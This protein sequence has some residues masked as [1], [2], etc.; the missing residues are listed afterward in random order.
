MLLGYFLNDCEIFP[1]A[2]TITST[3]SV[4][5]FHMW[6]IYILRSLYFNSLRL[7]SWSH[8]S[9]YIAV[10]IN[11][12]VP[13]SSSRVV[14]SGLLLGIV[15]S[16]CNIWLPYF[17]DL[18]LLILL[19]D[20]TMV[21]LIIL[22]FFLYY[23]YYYYYYYIIVIVIIIIIIIIVVVVVVVIIIIIIIIA[24]NCPYNTCQILHVCFYTV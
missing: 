11:I 22:T 2:H 15:L 5:T 9:L 19:N 16:A 6:C 21:P 12:H 24:L 1:V 4:V 8:L 20:H 23:Y 14:K 7:L 18:F 3:A 13:L 17:N 10:S